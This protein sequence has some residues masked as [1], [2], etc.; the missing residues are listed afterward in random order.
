[1]PSDAWRAQKVE[2]A[3]KYRRDYYHRHAQQEKATSAANREKY[4]ERNR[5]IVAEAKSTPCLDCG[6]SYPPYVMHFDHVGDDKTQEVSVMAAVPV[7]EAK[8]RAEIAKCE[9]VCG[10]CHAERTRQR[11]LVRHAR[12]QGDGSLPATPTH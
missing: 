3:R 6:M 7:S 10:N 11:W 1:V 4:R 12:R 5:R 9:V 8:L 2:R